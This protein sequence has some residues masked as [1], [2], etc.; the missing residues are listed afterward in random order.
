MSLLGPVVF[1]SNS[2]LGYGGGVCVVSLQG[3]SCQYG[4]EL[5]LYLSP[6]S[7]IIALR[8][9]AQIGGGFLF[10]S[11]P[12][13]ANS[14]SV[15]KLVSAEGAGARNFPFFA[16]GGEFV[17]VNKNSAGY[18]PLGATAPMHLVLVGNSTVLNYFPGESLQSILSLQDG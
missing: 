15:Q 14:A 2:A 17:Y 1:D 6:K 12:L 18:G 13:V 3:D 10:Y 16:M 5:Q 8:N 9:T 11:C 7:S 4:G